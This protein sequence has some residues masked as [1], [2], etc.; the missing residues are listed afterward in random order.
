VRTILKTLDDSSDPAIVQDIRR[1]CANLSASST[2]VLM[3][4][5]GHTLTQTIFHIVVVVSTVCGRG[6]VVG[7]IETSAPVHGGAQEV[8]A[9]HIHRS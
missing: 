6:E 1:E 9:N 2:A 4:V 5:R 8:V 3:E 7:S